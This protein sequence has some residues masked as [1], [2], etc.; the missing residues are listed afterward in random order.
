[1]GY[2]IQIKMRTEEDDRRESIKQMKDTF[3]SCYVNFPKS[4]SFVTL[5]FDEEELRLLIEAMEKME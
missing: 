4:E 2:K 1:M 5:Q 3:T